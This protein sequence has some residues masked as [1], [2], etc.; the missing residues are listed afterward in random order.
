MRAI[1]S[2]DLVDP[3]RDSRVLGA[4]LAPVLI[5]VLYSFMITD[6]TGKPQAEVG[7]V[8]ASQT[9]LPEVIRQQ[10]GAAVRLSFREVGEEAEL[11]RLVAAKKVDIGLVVRPGFDEAVK[12]GGSPTLRV[13]LPPSPSYGGDYVAPVLDRA[14]Q[15]LSRRGWPALGSSRT[16]G[17]ATPSCPGGR[18]SSTPCWPGDCGGWTSSAARH[19][20]AS[21]PG[22]SPA[23]RST[24][25]PRSVHWDS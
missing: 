3:L 13:L 25:W 18:W 16:P 21:G 1:L 8:T 19:T 11:R 9:R 17:R 23:R 14:L 12:S 4:L 7:V 24:R 10:A 20:R 6:Q 22:A 2:K 5:G 15:T